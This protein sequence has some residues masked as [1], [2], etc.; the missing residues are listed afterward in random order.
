[1]CAFYKPFYNN[2]TWCRHVHWEHVRLSPTSPAP[3]NI[4]G[5]L[6]VFT[7]VNTALQVPGFPAGT[8]DE[9]QLNSSSAILNLPAGS[10]VLYAEL[11]WA[12]TFRTDTEDVLPFLNDDITFTTPSGTFAVT[13]DPLPRSKVQ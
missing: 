7:T 11:V 1:M 9:W 8:T 13:P 4:F 5:T 12:G 3:G 2:S 10:S 6:A